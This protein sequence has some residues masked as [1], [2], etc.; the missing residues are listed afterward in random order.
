[1]QPS[2][3]KSFVTHSIAKPVI[4]GITAGL[5]DHFVMKNPDLKRCGMFGASVGLGIMAV[6]PVEMIVS[7]YFPTNTPMGHIGKAL[8]GRIVEVACG[9]AAAY[10]LNRFVLKNEYTS[11]DLLY[12]LG[13]IVVAD[14]VGETACEL[15]LI[16][17]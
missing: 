3:T 5:M 7:P 14:I 15:M 4:A 16:T 6:S 1:M 11:Q 12:K 13:I 9:S 10:S 17:H 8:E 2:K